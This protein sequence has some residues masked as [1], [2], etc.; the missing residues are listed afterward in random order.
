MCNSQPGDENRIREY[1]V[2]ESIGPEDK[3]EIR[4]LH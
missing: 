2:H 3:L 1:D 4:I